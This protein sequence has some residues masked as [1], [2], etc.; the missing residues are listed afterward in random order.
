MII[1]ISLLALWSACYFLFWYKKENVVTGNDGVGFLRTTRKQ[2]IVITLYVACLVDA[3]FAYFMCVVAAYGK[4]YD[5]EGEEEEEVKAMSEK[6]ASEK[7][8][9]EKMA[10][11]K[12]EEAGADGMGEPPAD[13]MDPPADGGGEGGDM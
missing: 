9:S 4:A 3:V 11:E 13:N 6:A 1:G 10:S 12:P 8:M 5:G 2:Q 7:M